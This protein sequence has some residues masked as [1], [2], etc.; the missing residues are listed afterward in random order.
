MQ[1]APIFLFC[2]KPY[3]ERSKCNVPATNNSKRWTTG[4]DWF[5]DCLTSSSSSSSCQSMPWP[6]PW[7]PKG[8]RQTKCNSPDNT[9]RVQNEASVSS[10]SAI[11]TTALRSVWVTPQINSSASWATVSPDWPDHLLTSSSISI[12]SDSNNIY[13]DDDG[14][15]CYGY[16]A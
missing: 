14:D 6:T 11:A 13:V 12:N 8:S 10:K 2:G 9:Q 7:T 3:T 4:Q 16:I 5:N 15:T 1:S